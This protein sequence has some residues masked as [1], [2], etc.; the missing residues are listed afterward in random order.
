MLYAIY[1]FE[2]YLEKGKT[3]CECKALGQDLG[4]GST[5][6]GIVE[7]A[8]DK[9]AENKLG[10]RRMSMGTRVIPKGNKLYFPACVKDFNEVF[11][12]MQKMVKAQ[13]NETL[14]TVA[15]AYGY[16]MRVVG[17]ITAADVNTFREW[18]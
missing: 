15:C 11:C 7:A 8:N 5:L 2:L 18:K 14:F 4:H 9:E 10:L 6:I 16:E 3:Y 13:K 17:P 1:E 12:I